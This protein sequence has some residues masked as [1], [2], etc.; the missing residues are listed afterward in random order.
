MN[1]EPF[2]ISL[3]IDISMKVM[4]FGGTSVGSVNSILSLKHI[5]ETESQK[6]KVIVV[7]SALGG[8]TDM[9]INTSALA[10]NGDDSYRDNFRQMVERHRNMIDTTITDQSARTEL[11]EYV[12]SLLEELRSIY[13]TIYLTHELGPKTIA[14]IVSYGERISSR[15]T[16]ALI[17]GAKWF[18]SR[19]FIKTTT[20]HGKY[21]LEIGITKQLVQQTFRH[22]PQVS[23]VPGFISTDS[24]TN[25]VTN[26]GRGG[27]DFTAAILAAALNGSQLE[28][29]TDVNGFLTADP[30]IIPSAH[31]ISELTYSEAMELCNFG[32]KVI[33]PPTLYPVCRKQIP[34]YVKNTFN[35]KNSGTVIKQHIDNDKLPIKGISSISKTT[36]LT[37]SDIPT[38][39]AARINMRI[40]SCLAENGVTA[41]HVSRT[42]ANNISIGIHDSDCP[43]ALT[44]LNHELAKELKTKIITPVKVQSGLTAIAI[45]GE[46]IHRITALPSR[47]TTMLAN[48]G[49]T[50]LS[51]ALNANDINLSL[52]VE[53]STLISTLTILHKTLFL[54]LR[55]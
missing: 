38:N 17:S 54:E 3:A 31:T 2:F 10:Q 43:T 47:L 23:V 45:V 19:K 20:K 15:I 5:V 26:L 49:I 52:I 33:Y 29:W 13:L 27:S 21:Q 18:D 39:N 41:F 9:L 35:P 11:Y 46:N 48:E 7:V 32:A 51:T 1:L 34:I 22:I 53:T 14:A 8:I 40:F 16:A 24:V 12:D 50:I 4:K 36:L 28:I 44:A 42:S 55:G 37:I 30:R 25:E 6:D